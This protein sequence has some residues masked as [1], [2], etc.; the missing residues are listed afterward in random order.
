VELTSD[1]IIDT[2][3]QL[4]EKEHI[5]RLRHD[6][7]HRPPTA[8]AVISDIR[9]YFN[10]PDVPLATQADRNG[11]VDPMDSEHLGFWPTPGKYHLPRRQKASM[12]LRLLDETLGIA[13]KRN[14]QQLDDYTGIKWYNT[15]PHLQAAIKLTKN[16][17]YQAAQLQ[18]VVA[19][20]SGRFMEV[21]D[22]PKVPLYA[23][24]SP[25]KN[26]RIKLKALLIKQGVDTSERMTRTTGWV[27][28]HLCGRPG[29]INPRHLRLATDAIDTVFRTVHPAL[30]VQR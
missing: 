5:V 28:T 20:A 7:P 8:H 19:F 27:A 4:V 14:P 16:R 12:T 1:Q 29:C 6:A 9:P 24:G 15:H 11:D 3:Q 18:R 25:H 23:L 10:K 26:H 30:K 2:L 21:D 17:R 13:I 22:W